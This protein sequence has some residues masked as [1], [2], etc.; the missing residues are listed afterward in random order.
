MCKSQR[1]HVTDVDINVK[2]MTG[3]LFLQHTL[4]LIYSRLNQAQ[5]HT[6]QEYA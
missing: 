2:I 6:I 4:K 5:Q 1:Q 3:N